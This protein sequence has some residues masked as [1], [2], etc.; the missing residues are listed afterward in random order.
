MFRNTFQ[1]GLLSILYSV[2]S[3]PLQFFETKVKNGV[4]KRTTDEDIKSL[5]LEIKSSNVSTTY[6]TCPNLNESLGIKLSYF[7]MIVKNLDRYFSFEVEII[8]NTDTKR[9]FRASN[10][11]K[12]T[13][14]RDFICTMPMRLEAGWNT[15]NLNLA[16]LTL[17]AFGTNYV[18]TCRVTVNANCRL[19]RIFFA[20][21]HY[22]EQELPSEFKLYLPVQERRSP[23]DL[24]SLAYD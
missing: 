18:E 15:I 2:G 16:D 24:P 13:R 21:R 11:Q 23:D 6:I 8:D 14:V 19:R 17:R 12:N 4:I 5:V 20:E 10:Y 9:R 3:Q 22:E 1:S 7:V